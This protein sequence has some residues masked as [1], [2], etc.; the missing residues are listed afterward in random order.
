MYKKYWLLGIIYL[1]M[2]WYLAIPDSRVKVIFCNVGQ[3]DATL[4]S[5]AYTQMLID[6]GPKNG[7]IE[8]CL[9]ENL[10]LGDKKIEMILLSHMDSDHSGALEKL[11]KSYNID[12]I[13][14]LGDLYYGDK[15]IG[16]NFD[17]SVIYPDVGLLD[18]DNDSIVGVLNYNNKNILFTGDIDQLVEKSIIDRVS[19]PIN[20]L[21]LSHHGSNTANSE[22]W[23]K[24]INADFAIVSVGK[25][26]YGHPNADVLKRVLGVGTSIVR[27]DKNG[28]LAVE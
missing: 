12:K 3:G 5:F 19:V 4:I 11:K 1:A 6:T 8:K 27:T 15:I 22:E 2:G 23:L 7:N 13:V 10:P 26:N 16:K 9:D 17:F 21:K 25:N 20:I 24:K 28:N 14:G 18:R